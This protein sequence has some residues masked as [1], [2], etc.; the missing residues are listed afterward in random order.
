VVY[1]DPGFAGEVM[2][3]VEQGA[4]GLAWRPELADEIQEMR[5]RLEASRSGRDLKRG[6]GGIVDVEFVVQMFQLK[7]ARDLGALRTKNTW[8]ALEALRNAGLLAEAEYTTLRAGYDFLRQVESRLRIVHNLSLDELP[9]KA[10]DLEK[11]AR[12]LGFE[13]EPKA[14]AGDQF[15]G[16]L[17]R[18]TT[19]IREVFLLLL[20]RERNRPNSGT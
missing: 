18:H 17:E 10:E 4:Y 6:F 7:Y 8:E 19:R 9:E 15:L 20:A 5:E 2:Q 3:A 16:E 13:P 1:G 11:L 14:N 12:R